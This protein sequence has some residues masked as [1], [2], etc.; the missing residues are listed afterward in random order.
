MWNLVFFLSIQSG[1][2]TREIGLSAG[3][4]PRLHP[5]Y[6]LLTNLLLLNKSEVLVIYVVLQCKFMENSAKCSC[7]FAKV[8]LIFD[9]IM[10]RLLN[11][12]GIVQIFM[13][14]NLYRPKSRISCTQGDP[15]RAALFFSLKRLW[16][17]ITVTESVFLR[18][19]KLLTR[20]CIFDK[21]SDEKFCCLRRVLLSFPEKS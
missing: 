16:W 18:I 9:K 15:P 13:K 19:V 11:L 12:T 4:F 21:K 17:L 14:N 2:A 7:Y 3:T 1:V 20:F 5:T 6:Q 8:T 10:L